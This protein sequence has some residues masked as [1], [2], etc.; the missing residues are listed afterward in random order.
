MNLSAGFRLGPYEILAPIG[1]GGMGEVYRARDTRLDRTVA[2]KI[3]PPDRHPSPEARQRFEREARTASQLTHP[4]ICALYDVGRQ[5][6]DTGGVDYLVMEYLEGETLAERLARGPL[7]LAETLR[8]AAEMTDAL[9]RAHRQGIVHRDLKPANIMLTRAGVKLLDFGLAK[10]AATA[11]APAALT[12]EPTRTQITQEET[13]LGTLQYMAPE[14]LEGREADARS[15]L[16]AF[17]AVLYEMATGRKA[18]SGG[19]KASLISAIMTV[20][21]PPISSLQPASPPALDRVIAVCLAKDPENRWQNAR[22]L[23][24]EL[25]FVAEGG[26]HGA[27]LTTTGASGRARAPQSAVLALAAGA[28]L[29]AGVL[30]GA[31]LPGWW[32]PPA[33]RPALM[34]LSLT[35]PEG[36]SL[37]STLAVS[38][39]GQRVALAAVGE[40][41]VSKIWI[42]PIG[43]PVATPLAGTDGAQFPF[44]SPDA[45][46]VAFYSD[47]KLRRVGIAGGDVQPLA[48]ITDFRGG[49]WG[50]RGDILFTTS[51]GEGLFRVAES[52]GAV[53]RVTTLD[54]GRQE[55]THRWPC[56]LPDGRRFLFLVVGREPG[57]YL[58]SLDG[59]E[60]RRILPDVLSA[61]LYAPPGFLLYTT[62]Q[63]LLA[64]GFDPV[65]G[66]LRDDP[67]PIAEGVWRDPII[68]GE[69]AFSA[70]ANGVVVYRAGIGGE[71]QLTW[72]DRA[73]GNLGKAGLP[74]SLSEPWFDPRMTK[75][76]VT[77]IDRDTGRQD[78]WIH[79]LVRG[80]MARFAGGSGV[81]GAQ[82]PVWSSDGKSVV[83]SGTRGEGWALLRRT[84]ADAGGAEETL[85]QDRSGIYADDW[86][87]DGRY[88]LYEKVADGSKYDLWARDLLTQQSRPLL[89]TEFNEYHATLSPDGHLVAYVSDETG[90]GEVYVQ[91]FP[92]A[93]TKWPISSG[94][95]DQPRWR[96]DGKEL[97]FLAPNSTLMSVEV[98]T[99]PSGFEV[100]APKKLFSTNLPQLTVIG[101]RNS[102]LVADN[103]RRFLVMVIPEAESAV[104]VVLNWPEAL[105]RD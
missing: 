28:A 22:D 91:G 101:M 87:S 79:D 16:F 69:T 35:R 11:P 81:S 3:L 64:R 43:A 74:G 96:Q 65:T 68:W 4:H 83:Y 67:L 52:G 29:L 27:A 55:E 75:V 46:S 63:S 12:A 9:D 92:V 10:V 86:S 44:W 2:I 102:Y 23:G 97:F 58:A 82:T 80:G 85:M 73:G 98:A 42:R 33:A 25:R 53:T 90:R 103:G 38:P 59:K 100:S 60:R 6:T 32:T 88:V 30:G 40:S 70:S 31:A 8:H 37:V 76:V 54:A 78:L 34:R 94:G 41:G 95:G 21:P 84:V 71:M 57:I 104:Q 36:T 1:A 99:D 77:H 56:F 51:A 47:G 18:F 39:D 24:R 17:G 89:A 5:E 105:R 7:P 62:G 26:A 19:S 13:I 61:A 49:A 48:D 14:Q 50:S 45:R 20:E 66:A 93:G 72:F 15:D